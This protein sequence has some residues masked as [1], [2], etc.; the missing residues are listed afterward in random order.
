MGVALF[1]RHGHGVSLTEA[2]ETLLARGQAVLRTLEQVRAEIRSGQ[3]GPS[4]IVTFAVPPAAAWFLVP[5]LVR[6]FGETHPNVFLRVI[7]GFSSHI[8]ERTLGVAGISWQ[9]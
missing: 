7:G 3:R 2:G 6:R 1:H 5:P 4:G 8:H 9:G